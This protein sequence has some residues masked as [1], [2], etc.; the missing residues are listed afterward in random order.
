MK[1]RN[2][3]VSNSSSS[4]FIVYFEDDE[5][6]KPNIKDI[7]LDASGENII[8]PSKD[9]CYEFNGNFVREYNFI[10]KLNWCAIQVYYV[11]EKRP[12]ILENF[13]EVIKEILG[14]DIVFDEKLF[15]RRDA[16]IDHQSASYENLEIQKFFENKDLIKKF[17]FG[18]KSYYQ[19]GHDN[20][21]WDD[22]P[23][24]IE[25]LKVMGIY[26]E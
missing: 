5:I 1:L 21:D 13:K 2:G 4:S 26:E 18:K 11:R 10:S 8:L 15:K 16:Y 24:Y 3:F 19:G 23:E 25:S 12:D 9:G 7:W 20:Y 6:I 22:F 17:I 14:L